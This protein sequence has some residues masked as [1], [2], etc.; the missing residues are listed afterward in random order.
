MANLDFYFAA[1]AE[2]EYGEE[3]QYFLAILGYVNSE[4][5]T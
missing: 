4:G 1:L 3:I 2:V 5:L